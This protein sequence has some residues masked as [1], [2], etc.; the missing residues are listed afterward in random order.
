MKLLEA[1]QIRSTRYPVP[2][3]PRR[4]PEPEWPDPDDPDALAKILHWL[5]WCRDPYPPDFRARRNGGRS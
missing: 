2:A 3:D 5:D 1:I 4:L